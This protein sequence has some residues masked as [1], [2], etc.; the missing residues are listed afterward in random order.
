MGVICT[1]LANEL[2]HHPRC[3]LD[4]LSA[5]LG[6]EEGEFFSNR[7][8]SRRRLPSCNVTVCY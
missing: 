3:E 6:A 4:F 5:L 8:D 7:D 1:N 2:G